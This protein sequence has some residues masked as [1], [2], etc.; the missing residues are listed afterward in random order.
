MSEFNGVVQ[1]LNARAWGDK[2]FHSFTLAG[3]DGWF[4]TGIAKPPQE[5]SSISFE[6][7]ED[8][9]G[10]LQV[11]TKSIQYRQDGTPSPAKLRVAASSQVGNG[12]P[13]PL[14]QTGYWED[15]AKRDLVNDAA[16]ELGASRNTALNFIDIALKHE[17]FKLPAQNKREEFLWELLNHYTAKLMEKNTGTNQVEASQEADV[18]KVDED[19]K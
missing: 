16:R 3:V 19:W 14:Q 17:V 5:G 4:S 7:K 1:R 10:Y 12:S 6:A 15:R 2:I 9:K 13:K 18:T 8:A 11:I